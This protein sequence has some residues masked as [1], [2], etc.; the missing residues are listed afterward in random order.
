MP[1]G[2]RQ[3]LNDRVY[4]R[5]IE[6]WRAGAL[7]DVAFERAYRL[8]AQ[9]IVQ[10]LML[11]LV[12]AVAAADWL[13]RDGSFAEHV[14]RLPVWL[15]VYGMIAFVVGVQVDR[16]ARFGS[17]N[18]IL[19]RNRAAAEKNPRLDLQSGKPSPPA[20]LV[21]TSYRIAASYAT[22]VMTLSC[23]GGVLTGALA[24]VN[25]SCAYLLPLFAAL[26][27]WGL[28][29]RF[30]RRTY[31]DISAD[32]IFCRSWGPLH[33][34]FDLFKAVYPRQGRGQR[35]VV[36]VPR[37]P[38]ELAPTLSWL[39]RYNLRSGENVPAHAGTLTLWTTRIGVDRDTF[40]HGLQSRIVRGALSLLALACCLQTA[41]CEGTKGVTT[42][43]IG[44]VMAVGG[45]QPFSV[46]D[47]CQ[48]GG[49]IGV[50]T[51]ETV[52]MATVTST[53]EDVVAVLPAASAPAEVGA[54][55]GSWVLY[56]KQPGKVHVNVEA[57]FDDGTHRT[58]SRD[59][60][61]RRTTRMKVDPLCAQAQTTTIWLPVGARVGLQV[62]L[63]DETTPLEG[64]VPAALEGAGLS[65]VGA[66]QGSTSP[67][68]Y[69][70]VP[71]AA[72]EVAL[73][74]AALDAVPVAL[75]AVAD[76]D[77][78]IESVAPAGRSP[79]HVLLNEPTVA[80]VV[81]TTGAGARLCATQKMTVR[82][83][84]PDVC[85][86][87]NSEAQWETGQGDS[88]VFKVVKPGTCRLSVA[89]GAGAARAFDMECL[90]Q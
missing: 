50:C 88:V 77:I 68:L 51:T 83:E 89:V 46:A 79:Y 73:T 76:A 26:A 72:G 35:G 62:T 9:A 15:V 81:Q 24:A 71:A 49:K 78:E 61:V 37:S 82:T 5:V 28:F 6:R 85:G 59:V 25:P 34:R 47:L 27:L 45:Y 56:A 67:L 58:V 74:S 70:W 12:V 52:T 4:G 42:S 18:E 1:R 57:D 33:Y 53:D 3:R 90:A 86:G 21:Q 11:T 36:L 32:G 2:F 7:E 39:G 66:P 19:S 84:T 29:L 30:D 22:W 55:P 10:P 13:G 87:R 31:V 65:F 20:V 54:A 23:S 40:M 38:A 41:A 8:R 63:F 16:L 17:R 48:A 60:E 75:H 64:L 80:F 43:T 69:S 14:A 44:R